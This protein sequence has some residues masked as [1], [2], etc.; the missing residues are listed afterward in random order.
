MVEFLQPT[1]R[2]VFSKLAYQE[3]QGVHRYFEWVLENL[4]ILDKEEV[5]CIENEVN[6][7]LTLYVNYE[8]TK[9]L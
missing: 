2:F 1:A 6:S 7:T 3:F 9:I 5:C 4:V 8:T